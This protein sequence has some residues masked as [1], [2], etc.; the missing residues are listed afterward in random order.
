MDGEAL[1]PVGI[2]LH[3]TH[4][5]ERTVRVADLLPRMVQI[6]LGVVIGLGSPCACLPLSA[7][8]LAFAGT[9]YNDAEHKARSSTSN[10]LA[11]R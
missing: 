6:P 10:T 1:R 9:E 5:I 4:E 8:I 7:A 2:G 11:A 3:L